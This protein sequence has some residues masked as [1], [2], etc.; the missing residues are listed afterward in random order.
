MKIRDL[1]LCHFSKFI[2]VFFFICLYSFYLVLVLK[3]NYP[4]KKFFIKRLCQAMYI[5]FHVMKIVLMVLVLV[6]SVICLISRV[7]SLVGK[8]LE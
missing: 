6:Y 4:T 7:Y 8:S 2:E 3:L 5:I 1:Q